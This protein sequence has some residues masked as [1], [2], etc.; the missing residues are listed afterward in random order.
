M[1]G[2]SEDGTEGTSINPYRRDTSPGPHP[3]TDATC[4]LCGNARRCFDDYG[5]LAC[6]D[7]HHEL[8]PGDGVR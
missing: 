2:L 1:V 6:Q 5:L 8:L 3:G 7:C 4:E